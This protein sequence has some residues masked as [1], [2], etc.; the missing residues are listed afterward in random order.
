M[1][2]ALDAKSEISSGTLASLE[3]LSA[4]ARR[5]LDPAMNVRTYLDALRRAGLYGDAIDVL[6]HL[7]PRQYAIAWG[8]ECLQAVNA[9]GAPGPAD[10]ATLAAAQRWLADP[11]EEHRRAAL[12]LADR[13]GYKSA[14][15]WLAAAAG[16]T[17]GSLLPA[18]QPEVPVPPTLAGDAVGAALR[19]AAATDPA[20]FDERL[21]LF[22]E[23]ALAAFSAPAT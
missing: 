4:A 18:G 8:C 2:Q 23:R 12:E 16:W 19:V 9:S 14:G 21:R 17:G 22:V 11:S 3:K 1:L 6:T 15:A 10:K 20:A 5:Q 7:L 13:L